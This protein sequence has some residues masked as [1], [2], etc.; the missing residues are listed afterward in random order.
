MYP[1]VSH[2]EVFSD[3]APWFNPRQRRAGFGPA[4]FGHFDQRSWGLFSAYTTGA[5]VGDFQ[6]TPPPGIPDTNRARST[7]SCASWEVGT[8]VAHALK[9]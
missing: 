3:F 4:T 7:G 5:E 9:I 2:R 1:F 6:D 8:S